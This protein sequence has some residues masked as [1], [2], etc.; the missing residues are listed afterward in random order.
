MNLESKINLKEFTNG[1]LEKKT[2]S[3]KGTVNSL[4]QYI[5]LKWKSISKKK[6]KQKPIF[7]ENRNNHSCKLVLSNQ[8]AK[9]FK[10]KMIE[11]LIRDKLARQQILSNQ[12]YQTNIDNP[13]IQNQNET[14]FTN[15]DINNLLYDNQIN[16]NKKEFFE[17]F[18]FFDTDRLEEKICSIY[19]KSY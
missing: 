4:E 5:A 19:R 13:Y 16:V 9:L 7:Q 14:L 6:T 2:I 8:N 17:T 18:K 10:K 3:I 12:F 11:S 1:Y 15:Q